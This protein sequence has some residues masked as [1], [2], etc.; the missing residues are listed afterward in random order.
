LRTV[1]LRVTACSFTFHIEGKRQ[2][3]ILQGA[4]CGCCIT[5]ELTITLHVVYDAG[6]DGTAPCGAMARCFS[7]GYCLFGIEKRFGAIVEG[8]VEE[9]RSSLRMNVGINCTRSYSCI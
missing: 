9:K 3:F 7:T 8:A 5:Y 4:Y 1:N 6:P 2:I